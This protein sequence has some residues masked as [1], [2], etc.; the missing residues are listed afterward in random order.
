MS[1]IGQKQNQQYRKKPVALLI[2]SKFCCVHVDRALPFTIKGG[3]EFSTSQSSTTRNQMVSAL[4]GLNTKHREAPM[5]FQPVCLSTLGNKLLRVSNRL[6]CSLTI[7]VDKTA[8][9][10]LHLPYGMLESIST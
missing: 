9:G 8:T 1:K 2:C 6:K 10:S 4:F 7:A 3:W 5:K